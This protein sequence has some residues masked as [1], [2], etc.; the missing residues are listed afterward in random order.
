M[1]LEALTVMEEEEAAT[2]LLMAISEGLNNQRWYSTQTTAYCLLAI[3]K[4][5]ASAQLDDKL[6]FAYQLPGGTATNAAS[7]KPMMLID[8]PAGT[9]AGKTISV[10]NKGS[11]LLFARLILSGQPV[12]GFETAAENGLGISVSYKDLANRNIDPRVL[13]QGT[14]FVAEVTIKHPGVRTIPYR[15]M[16]LNQIFP[17][18]WEI[19]NTRMDNVQNF[20]AGSSY[21][22]Q[23]FRDDRV[24]TFFDIFPTKT[25]TYRVQLNAAYQGRFYL[26]AVSCQAMYDE[27][28]SAR[29]AGS[30][31][32]VVRPEGI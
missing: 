10:E 20:E 4:F 26:P 3:G 23:D 21:D 13:P 9:S 25:R 27:T 16:A 19:L 30:W 17:S 32:E 14:D 7:D 15:E 22:Y 29:T 8:I 1:I 11:G 24:N 6:D 31:V 2:E 12:A 28:I 18:G 5:A